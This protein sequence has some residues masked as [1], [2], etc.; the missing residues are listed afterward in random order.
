MTSGINRPAFLAIRRVLKVA[1]ALPARWR[2]GFAVVHRDRLPRS[3]RPLI[4]ACNH[5]ARIDTVFLILALRPRFVVCGAK[6]PY[7]RTAPRRLLMA[8]ANILRVEGHDR[9]LADCRRLLDAGEILLV[10]PEMGRNPEAVGDFST[11]AAEVA[12]DRGV[13]VLPCYLHGTTRGQDG[14]VRLIVGREIVP[15]G[16]PAALTDRLRRA[17]LALAPTAPREEAS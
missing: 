6:P 16:D 17:I 2:W 1:L 15:E 11:W 4:V 12:L 3:R 5:A 9:F 7:F 8:I 14:A 13:P 10:Y